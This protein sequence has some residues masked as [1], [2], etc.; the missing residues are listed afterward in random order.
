MIDGLMRFLI[1]HAQVDEEVFSDSRNLRSGDARPVTEN[2]NFRHPDEF[3]PAGD[4]E[5]GVSVRVRTDLYVL[6]E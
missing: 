1:L 3:L 4:A 5:I 2:G 6:E